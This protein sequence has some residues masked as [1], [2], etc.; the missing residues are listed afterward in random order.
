MPYVNNKGA[1]QPA[2]PGSLINTFV[3]HCL[4]SIYRWVGRAMVLGSFQCWRVLL[5]WH[6]VGQGPA[7][8]AADVG[9]VGFFFFVFV[10][11]FISS[12]PSFLF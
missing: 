6:I 4:D 3:V 5:L 2:H 12:I 10:C 8:L 7:V 1:D 9:W 11:F